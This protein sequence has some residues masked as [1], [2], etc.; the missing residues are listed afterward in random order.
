[1]STLL[2]VAYG[3]DPGFLRAC[4][5]TLQVVLTACRFITPSLMGIAL[6]Y[7]IGRGFIAGSGLAMDWGPI[8][9]ATWIF[10]LL[11]FY[12]TLVDTLGTGLA[13]F[14]ALFSTD[15]SAAEAIRDLTTPASVAAA[16]RNDSMGIG[17]IVA[18]ASS[19]MTSISQTLS[20]FT[21]SGILTRLFTAT[22]VLIIRHIMQFIQQF[23][24]G[25][26]YVCGPIAMTLSVI[27]AFGQLALK[28]LQNFLAVQ[29]WGLTF[30]LL[31]T[32]YGF[33]AE[34]AQAPNG[35]FSGLTGGPQQSVDDEKFMVMSVAFVLLY[36]MVPYLT[37]MFIGSSAVQGF[38]GSMVGSAVGAATAVAGVASPG[39]G[40]LSSAVGRAL[41]NGG[42]RGGGGG[43]SAGSGGGSSG[44]G[45]EGSE[46]APS[47]AS[48]G[49]PTITMSE[50]LNPSYRQRASGIWTK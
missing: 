23:I 11:F 29:L 7:T 31:D 5:Q 25:F 40:G 24:L 28:W 32:I 48:S 37:S 16:A 35:L 2:M 13:A 19:L 10:F 50:A 43:P 44:G 6:L 12:Q 36:V 34:T 30:V 9:K 14:T 49:L 1:M 15:K 4:D 3:I 39:G 46:S 26:L 18:G 41:G 38:V 21:L 33:Y 42:S 45:S 17:D 27:P 8:I 22:A 20:S 47:S